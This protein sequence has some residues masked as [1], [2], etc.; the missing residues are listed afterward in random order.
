[1]TPLLVS[2]QNMPV[3]VTLVDKPSR[4]TT[5]FDVILASLGLTGVLV[6]IALGAGGITAFALVK[7]HQ[8]H[9]PEQDH[10]PS[11]TS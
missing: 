3:I 8:R 10:L 2:I 4:E 9:R 1:M 11:L 6:L 5:L 7:W